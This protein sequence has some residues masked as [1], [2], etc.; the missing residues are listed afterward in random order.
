M[1]RKIIIITVL[2][3]VFGLATASAD[4][5]SKVGTAG[6]QFL[7]IGLGARYTALGEAATAT[8]DDAYGLY[9]NPAALANMEKAEVAFTTVDWIDDVSLS[10]IAFAYP[11]NTDMTIG[12][13]MSILS[14]GDME[15][16][17]VE[18]PDGNGRKFSANSFAMIAGISK[19]LTDR[20]VFGLNFKY[21]SEQISE[22]RSNGFCFDMG[23]L[24]YTGFKS[25][26]MGVNISN[27]GP[28][29]KFDG[30]ELDQAINPDPD[31]PNRD[32]FQYQ[33][34]TESYDLPLMFRIGLA[35]DLVDSYR[36]RLTIA[37]D[38]RDPNDNIG[39]FSI[40]SEY[41][42]NEMFMLRGG[43][44]FNYAEEGLTLGGGL[45]LNP[46]PTTDL[47]FDYAWADFGRLQ[48]TH[49]FSVGIRF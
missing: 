32:E 12:F 48:S 25:L 17:T 6:A 35:Y 47:V 14:M 29:M 21:V 5:F 26:R 44:K 28:E 7:K 45:R 2:A 36:S 1:L 37:A 27:L 31:N 49:R 24:L 20:F 19:K 41:S 8:V 15:V 40:G 11:V 13:G 3:L 9:W 16:T 46:T 42:W 10:H 38:A 39:Q 33:F 30:N 43:Y 23:T 22:Q 4:E 18:E 34:D